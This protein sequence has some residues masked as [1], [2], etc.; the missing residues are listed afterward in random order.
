[1]VG[2][3]LGMDCSGDIVMTFRDDGT[4]ERSW[5]GD[6]QMSGSHRVRG[7]GRQTGTYEDLGDEL[8]FRDVRTVVTADFGF[9][10]AVTDDG[11]AT[12]RIEGDRLAIQFTTPD[13]ATIVQIYR[14]AG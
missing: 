8:I 14:R 7:A 1:M 9:S 6:C 10:F 5:Q 11:R 13:G 3:L 12:Y 4:F 2:C